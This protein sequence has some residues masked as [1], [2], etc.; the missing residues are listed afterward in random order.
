MSNITT[1]FWVE[2]LENDEF[3]IVP[4]TQVKRVTYLLIE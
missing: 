4:H 2:V 1:K 3:K